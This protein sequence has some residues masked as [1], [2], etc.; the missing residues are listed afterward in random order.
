MAQDKAGWFRQIFL[1]M[2][3]FS[4]LVGVCSVV[5]MTTWP[6]EKQAP[7][8]KPTF[9]I[10]ATCAVSK[11]PCGIAYGDLADAKAKGVYTTLEPAEA[12]GEIEEAQNWLKW[13]K[14]NGIYEV[15]ASSWHFQ[16]TVRYKVENDTPVLIAYQ[17]VDVP[18]AFYYALGAGLFMLTGLYLRKLRG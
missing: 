10:V 12:T 16:T 6:W 9:R 14:E 5:F 18:R 7:V 17:D 15:K 1:A 11:E 8:W 3:I 4:F 2:M 13:K